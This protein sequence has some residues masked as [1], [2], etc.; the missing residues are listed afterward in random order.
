MKFINEVFLSIVD[1]EEKKVFEE[2]L[3]KKRY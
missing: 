2:E 3:M 1:D